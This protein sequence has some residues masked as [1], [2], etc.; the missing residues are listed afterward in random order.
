MAHTRNHIFIFFQQRNPS[1]QNINV[2]LLQL[3]C[4]SA[5]TLDFAKLTSIAMPDICSTYCNDVFLWP[6]WEV[7][8][9]DALSDREVLTELHGIMDGRN[10]SW[11]SINQLL[12]KQL[13]NDSLEFTLHDGDVV[14]EWN[15][16]CNQKKLWERTKLL[17]NNCAD[18]NRDCLIN[19]KIMPFKGGLY[20]EEGA[21]RI[22]CL[23]IRLC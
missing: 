17:S 20:T 7:L 1:P 15:N 6:E 8:R 5:S 22:K 2:K 23:W 12:Q 19:L 13:D 16:L 4:K 9:V 3:T 21:V 11:H 18:F 10:Y 14:F